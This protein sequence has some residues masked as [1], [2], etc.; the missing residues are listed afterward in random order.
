MFALGADPERIEWGI[1]IAR[2]AR[3]TKPGHDPDELA[4]GAYVNVVLLTLTST[5]RET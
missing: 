3:G 5:E 4:Y 1:E 2:D